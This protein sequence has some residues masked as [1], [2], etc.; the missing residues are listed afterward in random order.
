[1]PTLPARFR[2][3][4]TQGLLTAALLAGASGSYADTAKTEMHMYRYTNDQ[5]ALVTG[6]S[7]SPE[8][9]RKGYQIVT[10]TGVVLSTVAPEPTA[11][12]R[13]KLAE[14]AKDKLNAEQQKAHDKDLLLRYN[15]LDDIAIAKQ[16]RLDEIN[17][18]I[19]L[20]N[21]NVGTLKSQMDTEHQR[22]AIFER[23]GQPVPKVQLDK[24]ADLQQ[25]IKVTEDQ[26]A[27]R[28]QELVDETARFDKDTARLLVL[29]KNRGK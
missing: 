29:N 12:E 3:A 1:M 14:Q 26:V 7:I 16:R 23:N 9:A 15:S 8:Y 10:V 21:S 17:N 18:Q 19:V 24:I 5:G 6:N 13:A 4:L 22:A 25:A 28:K 27:Q 20:L 11:E 2:T